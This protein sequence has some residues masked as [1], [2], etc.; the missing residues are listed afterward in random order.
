MNNKIRSVMEKALQDKSR[1]NHQ[2]ALERLTDAIQNFPGEPDLYIEAADVCLEAGESIQ[3]AQF[4]R[5][6][7]SKFT[8]ERDRLLTFARTKS[9]ELNDSVLAKFSLDHSIKNRDLTSA[10]DGLQDIKDQ[11]IRELLQR[12]RNKS[13]SFDTSDGS[14][15]LGGE[16][17]AAAMS[18]ALLCL[19]LGRMKEA[20]SCLMQ[21]LESKPVENEVLQPFLGELEGSYP[22]SG[23]IRYAH[24]CCLLEMDDVDR[25]MQRFIAAARVEPSVANDC[26]ER[27]RAYTVKTKEPAEN[28]KH[29]VVEI[30]LH[31]GEVARAAELLSEELEASPSRATE[32]IEQVKPHLDV[33]RESL[34]LHYLYMTAALLAEQTLRVLETLKQIQHDES[35]RSE[36]LEWLQSRGKEIVLAPEILLVQAELA[37]EGQDFDQ[38]VEVLKAIADS[39]PPDIPAVTRVLEKYKA[40]DPRFAEMFTEYAGPGSSS[41]NEG[42]ESSIEHFESSEFSFAAETA[43]TPSPDPTPSEPTPAT[44]TVFSET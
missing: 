16:V 10:L 11:T 30:L 1:G 14:H 6:A 39:S 4:L 35:N 28:V 25:A 5:R 44:P 7:H 38:A 32:I 42:D 29:A 33:S 34:E 36:L 19:R 12:S 8:A 26:L 37:I 41:S 31:Q 40:S 2:K 9:I 24:A 18:E 13:Q 17:L 23:R 22:K 15:A 20:V 27:I 21:I 3:A 43:A